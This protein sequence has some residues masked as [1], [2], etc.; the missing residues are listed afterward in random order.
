MFTV[1]ETPGFTLP[2]DVEALKA[3]ALAMAQKAGALEAEVAG[4]QAKNADTEARVQDLTRINADAEERIKNLTSILKIFSR[5]RFGRKSEK[6]RRI[7]LTDEQQAEL[8]EDIATGIA[9][10]ETPVKRAARGTTSKRAPRPRKAFPAHLERIE[11]TIEPDVPPEHDGKTKVLIRVETSERL[12]VVPAKFRVLVTH[13]PV[14]AFK[15]EDGV[16]QAP[17]PAHIIEGGIPTEAL[18]AQVA[19]SKYADGLPLYR[20]EAI[21]A[22]DKVEISRGLMAQWM[23]VVGFELIIISDY[24][25]EQ[26]RHAERIFADET[27][28]PILAPGTG[29]AQKSYLWAYAVDNRPF[30]G[31]GPIMVAFRFEDSRAGDC[32]AEHLDGYKGVVQVDGYNAYNSIAR[33]EHAHEGAILSGCW[34]H[35]RRK[36]YDLHVSDALP[37]ATTTVERMKDLWQVEDE[38]RG[39]APEV[40]AKARQERSA[41]VVAD[42]F[43]L[44]EATL[45]R[46]SGKSKLAVAIRYAIKRRA[47]FEVFLNNGLA[48]IDSNVV[49]RAI[50]P[51]TITRKNSLFA[52]SDGG[53]RA[54][55]TIATVTQTC[56]MNDVDPQA[57][58]TQTLE[59]LANGWPLSQLEHLMPWNFKP[60]GVG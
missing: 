52:G 39:Q 43:K 51:Q 16:I 58:L 14:Y 32:V 23:G 37:A 24:I 45:P 31:S 17:A 12:D 27:T 54:W 56:K 49:E 46:I 55:A 60:N 15:G 2:D 4:L 30:G 40:R 10:L 53:G 21:Y 38:I 41:P 34:A 25:L 57:W 26:I 48:D 6:L 7:P 19:V 50:R 18:L 13:R 59:R 8:F 47:A 28:L 22:R 36:F 35:L 33:K 29:K 9:E 5:A 3:F 1:M 44:W 11:Q 20:Q 42:L